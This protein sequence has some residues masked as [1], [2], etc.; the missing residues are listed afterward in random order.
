[1]TVN[2]RR[3][4]DKISARQREAIILQVQGY[5]QQLVKIPNPGGV[6]SLVS[7]GEIFHLQLP[8]RGPFEST[9]D[10]LDTYADCDLPSI[11]EILPSS[12][13]VFSHMDWDLSNLILYPN[14]DAVMGVIDWERAC[15]FPEGGRSIH[16][17]CYQWKGWETLFDGLEFPKSS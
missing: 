9:A 2:E 10:F 15:F 1:V 5:I 17:M 14:L 8:H 3:V 6:R 12:R 16:K 4:W 13:P 7:S 11:H